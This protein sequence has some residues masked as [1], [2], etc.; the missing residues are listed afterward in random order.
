LPLLNGF[1]EWLEGQSRKI[2]PKSPIGQA[3]SYARA[4]GEDL[5]TYTPDGEL[6]I[7]NNG[8]EWSLRAQVIGHKNYLFVGSNRGG[9]TAAT[10][11]SL[12]ASCK[13]HRVDPF[14]YLKNILEQLPAHPADRLGELLPDAWSAANPDARRRAAS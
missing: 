6:S 1:G 2:L 10:L 7:N 4:Q 5:Q 13:H 9:R 3:I 8:S 12:V 11:Y 14:A